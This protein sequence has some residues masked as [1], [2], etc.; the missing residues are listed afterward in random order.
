M[1]IEGYLVWWAGPKL[2]GMLTY[3]LGLKAVIAQL[4]NPNTLA[5]G[6]Q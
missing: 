2:N 6:R 1:L 4:S 3:D 5:N